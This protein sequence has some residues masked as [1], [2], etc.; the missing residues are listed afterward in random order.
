[1][2]SGTGHARACPEIRN[3]QRIAVW[4]GE[5]QVGEIGLA[6]RPG[7]YGQ[8]LLDYIRPVV[9]ACG[10]IIVARR[11][12]DAR[13]MAEFELRCYKDGLE[14]LIAERTGQLEQARDAAEAANRAKSSF[15]ANMSHELRTPMNAIM[16]MTGLALRQATDPK[17]C[18]QLE[19][20]QQAS[21][22]L[23]AI[24]NDIL[25][26]SK[27]EAER[28]VLEQ[29]TFMLG[30][31][32][33]K[34]VSLMSD[35]VHDKHLELRLNMHPE[36]ENQPFIGDP[37]RLAQILLNLVANSVKF[38]SHGTI[39]L[40]ARMLEENPIE[41]RLRLEVED[42]GI[43]ISPDDQ[44]RLFSAF[45]QADS[46]M[47]RKYGGT[48]L[49]LV[50]SKR[51]TQMMGGEMGVDSQVGVGSTF[52]FTARLSK[53]SEIIRPAL[54][55]TADGANLQ[56]KARHAGAAVLLA[57]DDPINREIAWALLDDT[58]LIVDLAEDGQAALQLASRKR[59]DL[60]L[61]DMQMPELNGVDATRGIR[62]LP[63]CA[64]TPIIALTANAF[65][66]D[67]QLCLDAGMNDHI[68]KPF[69]PELLFSSIL[70]WLD[71]S[72]A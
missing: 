72:R 23:L 64:A 46:S 22:H 12:R 67:R 14:V 45:E 37:H 15:L 51:L 65:D 47:T 16:G 49:G 13:K 52:W 25:D 28:M 1:M 39:T 19:K 24:I 32:L 17:L 30:D 18:N 41:M 9:E 62:A 57:E 55:V 33:E 42:T 63:G 20:V 48:G 56:I 59:Y 3:F 71:I 36:V 4:Y 29:T 38:T 44:K 69:N 11:D 21:E 2:A 7:G 70:K 53:A 10:R 35:K 6:N 66:E 50:I 5:S 60:I 8:E 27:I 34:V 26:I 31:V 40:R 68:A 43:G 54:A 58:G 61:M